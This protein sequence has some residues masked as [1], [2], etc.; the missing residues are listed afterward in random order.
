MKQI[1]IMKCDP[2]AILPDYVHSGD[3]GMDLYSTE[4]VVIPCGKH[5]LVKTGICIEL[6]HGY[7]AQIRSKSG[8]ALKNGVF[9][10]NSPGTIDECYRGEICVILCNLGEKEYVINVGDKIAQMVFNKVEYF[11]LCETNNLS[12]TDRGDAGFGSTGL[13]KK[14]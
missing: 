11:A 14:H 12:P 2:K 6:P 5:T 4:N 13:K 7:E 9:C 8:I 10:L 1:K 3:A